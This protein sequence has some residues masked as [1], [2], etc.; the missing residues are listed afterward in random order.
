MESRHP[1]VLVTD[2][3]ESAKSPPLFIGLIG[4]TEHFIDKN[5][6]DETKSNLFIFEVSF[7]HYYFYL[8]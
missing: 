8:K 2:L 1:L 3:L 5:N 7:S 4:L 6:N